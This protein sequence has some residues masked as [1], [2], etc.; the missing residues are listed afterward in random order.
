MAV[1]R[2]PSDEIQEIAIEQG[3]R[4]LWQDGLE[5]VAAGMTSLEEIM[6][7]VA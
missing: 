6:R 3:M 7:V 1:D 5:K 2:R 4:T